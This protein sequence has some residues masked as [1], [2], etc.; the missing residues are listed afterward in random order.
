MATERHR[1]KILFISNKPAYF[2]IQVKNKIKETNK[3]NNEFSIEQW[4]SKC[5]L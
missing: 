5:G 4:F 2:D 3:R 1:D